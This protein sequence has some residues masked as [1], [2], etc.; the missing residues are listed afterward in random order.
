MLAQRP[1]TTREP[2][3]DQRWQCI[4]YLEMWTGYRFCELV[5]YRFLNLCEFR[6]IHDF[7]DVFNFVQEHDFLCTID[8][9]PISEEPKDHLFMVSVTIKYARKDNSP[10]QSGQH[11][12][13]EIVRYNKPAVGDTCLGF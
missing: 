12:F 13:L 6:R 10:L 7:E 8:F 9:W 2:S 5:K 11:P 1:D 3:M 4:T